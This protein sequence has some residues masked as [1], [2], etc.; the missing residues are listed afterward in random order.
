MQRLRESNPKIT[1]ASL[2]RDGYFQRTRINRIFRNSNDKGGPFPITVKDIVTLAIAYKLNAEQ[3]RELLF[4]AFPDFR[5]YE[6][7]IKNQMSLADA[8]E[9]LDEQALDLLGMSILND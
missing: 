9:I 3:T 2:V 8:N 5:F 4:S 6:M 7:F 1:Q